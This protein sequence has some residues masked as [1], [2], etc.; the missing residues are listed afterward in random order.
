VVCLLWVTRPGLVSLSF[1]CFVKFILRFVCLL[2]MSLLPSV[3][4]IRLV[5]GLATCACSRVRH[6]RC[7]CPNVHIC[8]AGFRFAHFVSILLAF[9]LCRNPG[10]FR[11]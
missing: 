4:V 6:A 10:F 9:F 3:S 7:E 8:S 11:R 5:R 1:L 2:V